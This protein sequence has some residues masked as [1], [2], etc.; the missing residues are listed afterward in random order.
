MKTEAGMT[1]S[2]PGPNVKQAAF[3][4]RSARIRYTWE[5]LDLAGMKKII[6]NS[7][8]TDSSRRNSGQNV[9]QGFAMMGIKKYLHDSHRALSQI[10]PSAMSS[11]IS[12]PKSLSSKKTLS[13]SS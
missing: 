12:V 6:E 3:Q 13:L 7:D 5:N 4:L 9:I 8:V 1:N 10:L 11:S 2:Q